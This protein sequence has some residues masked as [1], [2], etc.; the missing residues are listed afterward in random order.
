VDLDSEDSSIFIAIPEK[1]GFWR[2]ANSGELHA[3]VWY[4]LSKYLHTSSSFKY[5]HISMYDP[6]MDYTQPWL[7][8]EIES[9]V[10]L[11]KLIHSF[12]TD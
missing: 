9:I 10:E 1:S 7:S 6:E 12:P 5:I 8:I 3:R 4:D 2:Y 11:F